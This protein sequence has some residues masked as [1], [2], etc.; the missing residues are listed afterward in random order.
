MCSDRSWITGRKRKIQAERTA[1][2]KAYVKEMWETSPKKIYKWIRGTAAV[3]DI[4][5]L[6]ENGFALTPDQAAQA[7]LGAW[8]KLWQPGT[9]TFPHKQTSKS[10]WRT[11]DLKEVIRHCPLGKA[12]GA[13]RWSIAELR[14]YRPGRTIET[15]K[16]T[17]AGK[18]QA[19]IFLDCSKCYKRVPL[20]TLETFALESGYPLYALYA[21]LDMYSGRRRV[22]LQG[23]VSEPVT[24]THGMPPHSGLPGGVRS[25]EKE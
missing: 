2:W 10:S 8:S 1:S 17:A 4:A 15:E 25:R 20:H 21:A 14:L 23:A 9:T 11:G 19:G 16:T 13:D 22:L 12:R 7:E 24:A 18:P 6:H 5:I 3:W